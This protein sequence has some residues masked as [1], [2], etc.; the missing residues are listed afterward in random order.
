MAYP[1]VFLFLI[2]RSADITQPLLSAKC[3]P[4]HQT[5]FTKP[6]ADDEHFYREQYPDGKRRN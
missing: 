5:Q 3:F 1:P 6:G 4:M 2:A